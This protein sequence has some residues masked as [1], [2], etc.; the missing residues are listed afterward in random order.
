MSLVISYLTTSPY[1]TSGHTFYSYTEDGKEN[2]KIDIGD[3]SISSP[4]IS[5]EGDIYLT[6]H[7]GDIITFTDVNIWLY[8]VPIA[9]LIISI[10]VVTYIIRQKKD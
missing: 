1:F 2:K 7:N 6:L 9:I 3:S 5:R 4:T 8:A 10:I